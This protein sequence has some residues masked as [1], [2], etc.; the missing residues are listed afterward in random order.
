MRHQKT[1]KKL[2]RTGSHRLALL[3]NLATALFRHGRIETT[4]I[5]A[6]ALPSY[7]DKLITL[8]KRGDLHARRMAARD[9]HDH[10]MLQK[11]FAD[12]G[13]RFKER[14]GGYTRVLK[15]RTRRGD[16]AAL[17]FIELVDF[18]ATSGATTHE[19][20]AAESK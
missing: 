13:P 9:V 10:E 1:I 2:G 4:E 16:A 8:G 6:K 11:L 5:K 17:A 7:A 14:Q 3:R 19:K 15:T 12:I 20:A 18:S